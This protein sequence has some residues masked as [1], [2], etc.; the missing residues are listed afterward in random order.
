MGRETL[1]DFNPDNF[2]ESGYAIAVVCTVMRLLIFM[3]CKNVIQEK[4]ETSPRLQKKRARSNKR[5]LFDYYVLKVRQSFSG[6][7]EKK[8]LWSNRIHLCR[9]HFKNYTDENPLFGKYTGLYWWQPH[10]RGQKKKGVVVKDY[11]MQGVLGAPGDA[12]I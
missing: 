11:D 7:S 12:R 2:G 4:I 1:S 10:A 6:G 3:N 9:G 8:D 5:P